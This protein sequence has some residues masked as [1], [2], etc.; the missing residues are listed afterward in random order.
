MEV[1]DFYWIYET[2]MEEERERKTGRENHILHM[3]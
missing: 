1:L 2:K 3:Q